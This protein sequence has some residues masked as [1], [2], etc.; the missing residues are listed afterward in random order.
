MRIETSHKYVYEVGDLVWVKREG[1]AAIVHSVNG[2]T[3][4]LSY[5]WNYDGV[6]IKDPRKVFERFDN[7]IE[8]CSYQDAYKRIE[9]KYFDEHAKLLECE[10]LLAMNMTKKDM[11]AYIKKLEAK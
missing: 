7:D 1:F 4:T 10:H 2:G 11:K 9:N 8:Y 5:I 6:L 3:Y